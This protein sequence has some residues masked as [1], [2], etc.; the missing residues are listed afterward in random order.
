V[1]FSLCVDVTRYDGPSRRVCP[2]TALL[3]WNLLDTGTNWLA[4]R[5][6]SSSDQPDVGITPCCWQPP[7]PSDD[8]NPRSYAAMR[9]WSTP[10]SPIPSWLLAMQT[11][12]L[13][14]PLLPRPLIATFPSNR[15]V[16]AAPIADSEARY[17]AEHMPDSQD[18]ILDT[19]DLYPNELSTEGRARPLRVSFSPNPLLELFFPTPKK[20]F[21]HR[22]NLLQRLVL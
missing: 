3:G 14:L 1:V 10:G 19:Q 20:P 17:D 16:H 4:L 15:Q 13:L 6:W 5:D 18:T 2:E 22:S 21:S 7:R 9:Y 8:M 12:L 11:T